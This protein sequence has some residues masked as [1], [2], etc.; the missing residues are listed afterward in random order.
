[1]HNDN[2]NNYVFK[3]LRAEVRGSFENTFLLY[4]SKK[5]T[6]IFM[7]IYEKKNL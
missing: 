6:A 3:F 4:F 2:V 7:E 1:M 5:N